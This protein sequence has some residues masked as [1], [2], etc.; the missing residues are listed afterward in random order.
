VLSGDCCQHPELS[1]GPVLLANSTSVASL[2]VDLAV[3]RQ[4]VQQSCSQT[5]APGPG[6]G[7]GE[8]FGQNVQGSRVSLREL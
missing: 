6:L 8:R 1:P 7:Y 5:L 2:S 3:L 4:S